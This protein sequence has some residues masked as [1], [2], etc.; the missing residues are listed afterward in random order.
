MKN[1]IQKLLM[2]I[3]ILAFFVGILWIGGC[4]KQASP[5]GGPYDM[6]A[7]R[8]IKSVPLNGAVEVKDKKIKLYFDENVKIERQSEN[9]IF[10]PP[11]ITP[12][13]ISH[14]MGKCIIVEYEDELLPNTTYTIDFTNGI[15]DLNEGNVLEGFV[16]AF[17]TGAYLDT[18]QIRGRVIDASSLENMGNIMVGVYDDLSDSI[19]TKKAM[20]RTA[21]TKSDGT[22]VITNLPK[23]R[24]RVYALEDMDRTFSYTQNSEGFAFLKDTV[25]ASPPPKI[26]VDSTFQKEKQDSIVETKQEMKKEVSKDN[27]KEQEIILLF[28]THLRKTQ[29]LQKSERL[30]PEV[31]SF[32]FSS[33]LDS[34]PSLRLISIEK[35]VPILLELSEDKKEVKFWITDTLL[36]QKDTLMGELSYFSIDSLEKKY[37]KKDTLQFIYRA[38]KIKK[39]KQKVDSLGAKKKVDS[40]VKDSINSFLLKVEKNTKESIYKGSLKDPFMLSLS[41]PIASVDT[42][43][44]NLFLKGD[45]LQEKQAFRLKRSLA[46]PRLIELI[47]EPRYGISYILSLEEGALLGIYGEKSK[48]TELEFKVEEENKFGSLEIALLDSLPTC[49]VFVELLNKQNKVL[50]SLLVQDT[51][52]RIE[53]LPVGNYFIRMWFDKNGDGEWTPAIYPRQYPEPMY[54]FPK[55]CVVRGKILT[56][57]DWHWENLALEK[58]RPK[59][60]ERIQKKSS[61]NRGVRE[62]RNL[63]EEYIERMR[64]RFGDRWNPSNKDRKI[65]GLPSREEEKKEREAS[66]N[67]KKQRKLKKDSISPKS[68]SE[69]KLK[70]KEVGAKN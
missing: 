57:E 47:A 24:Y 15:V 59:D 39:K 48:K 68:N 19:F 56:R 60:L 14:G 20:K 8:F 10:S 29:N 34:L 66:K 9:V 12:P 46:N 64:K 51:L 30:F 44:W 53:H 41:E 63:N 40:L 36:I 3:S 22:F 2:P 50:D 4:A 5:E 13:Q 69:E 55:V 52:L 28:S 27:S 32:V 45:S 17:S 25:E 11:Q 65:L 37:L 62:R 49:P 33:P 38:S 21:R 35:N 1:T 70:L 43:L 16:F 67:K 26:K 61:N 6:I 58:Q 18:M 31:L 7:P 54:Y 23:G 42:M